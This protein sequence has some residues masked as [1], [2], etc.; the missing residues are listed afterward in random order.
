MT[1]SGKSRKPLGVAGSFSLQVVRVGEVSVIL[2]VVP[3][4]SS[5]DQINT[6]V[7][8]REVTYGYGFTE[9]FGFNLRVLFILSLNRFVKIDA[10]K[11]SLFFYTYYFKICKYL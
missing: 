3:F 9:P 2:L 8:D 6:F 4:A 5:D 1:K 10:A 11:G 7:A